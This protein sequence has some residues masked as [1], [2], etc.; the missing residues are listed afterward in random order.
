M[1]EIG[2]ELLDALEHPC[3]KR[4]EVAKRQGDEYM[5]SDFENTDPQVK[6]ASSWDEAAGP[7]SHTQSAAA[8]VRPASQVIAGCPT[9]SYSARKRWR[10]GSASAERGCLSIRTDAVAPACRP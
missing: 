9:K 7:A 8:L 6:A 4:T 10:I 2:L 5:F 1:R 3:L